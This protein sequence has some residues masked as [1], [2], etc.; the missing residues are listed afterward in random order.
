M[1][2]DA[3]SSCPCGSGKKFK[4]CCQPI[5]IEIDKAFRQDAEGQHEAALR[6]MDQVV[7]E[8]PA[9]PEA[10]GRKAQLLYQN[11]RVEDAEETLQKAFEINPN[12]PFGH[13]LHGLF[14]QHEGEIPGALLLFR[15]AAELYDPEAKDLL[16][17]V[18]SLIADCEMRLNRPVAARAAL[19][20]SLHCRPNDEMRQSF[21][22]IFGDKSQLPLSAR[23]DY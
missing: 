7:A 8:H 6:T 11:D 18:Y 22:E 5:H 20:I 19:K 2:L 15:K 21:E 1:A 13:L 9:N 3:Y 16:A 23:R 10:L 17:Q 14:R 12:Y 4:W